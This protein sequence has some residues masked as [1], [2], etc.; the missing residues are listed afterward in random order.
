[1][2]TARRFVAFES[3]EMGEAGGGGTAA[4]IDPRLHF[5][6]ID[7]ARGVLRRTQAGHFKT[8]GAPP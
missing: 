5:V 1:M 7:R 4:P 6:H 8:L 2:H 3:P